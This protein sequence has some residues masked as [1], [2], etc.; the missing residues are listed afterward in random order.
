MSKTQEDSIIRDATAL[1]LS[2]GQIAPNI[3]A[4]ATLGVGMKNSTVDAST[5]L[6]FPPVIPIVLHVPTMYD[7]T[8]QV[9]QN[10]KTLIESMATT[11]SGVDLTL[12]LETSGVPISND[13]QEL[14]VPTRTTIAQP[15]PTFV[16]NELHGCM[17]WNLMAQWIKDIKDPVTMA[18]AARMQNAQDIPFMSSSYSMA[19]LFIQPDPTLLPERIIKT[20]LISNMFPTDPGGGLGMEKTVGQSAIKERTVTMTGYLQENETINAIGKKM[21]AF[22]LDSK[23]RYGGARTPGYDEVNSIIAE[24]GVEKEVNDMLTA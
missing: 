19:C 22:L 14:H 9:G 13:S 12:A 20:T 8:P 21:A 2:E 18:F 23:A 17:I 1:G 16:F 5:P 3:Q 11:I 7:N 10:I 24:A 4:G 6:V 15:T